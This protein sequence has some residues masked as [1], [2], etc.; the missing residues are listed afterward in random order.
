MKIFLLVLLISGYFCRG[1]ESQAEEC[2]IQSVL[3]KEIIE[4]VTEM[5]EKQGSLL[6]DNVITPK[7]CTLQNFCKAAAVLSKYKAEQLGL[8]EK[9][10]RLPR[11]L[12]AYTR[13]T[14]CKVSPMAEQVEFHQLLLNIKHCAQKEF[15]DPCV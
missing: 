15:R 9:E 11:T 10:W 4:D 1:A 12:I 6:V 13:K 7:H 8:K 3:L 14:T 2:K 5:K